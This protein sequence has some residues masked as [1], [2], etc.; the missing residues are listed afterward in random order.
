MKHMREHSSDLVVCNWHQNSDYVQWGENNFDVSIEFSYNNNF[1]THIFLSR[2]SHQFCKTKIWTLQIEGAAK[3]F[4]FHMPRPLTGP[5]M[6]WDD[7]NCLCSTKNGFTYYD[8]PK[9]F[10]P[11]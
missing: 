10:V 11:G 1:M 3:C 2:S 5:R 7:P 8:G 9:L 4:Y 6:F